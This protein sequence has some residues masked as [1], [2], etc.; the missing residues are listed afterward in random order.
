MINELLDPPRPRPCPPVFDDPH[1]RRRRIVTAFGTL[2]GALCLCVL[3]VAAGVLYTDA[4]APV[5]DPAGAVHTT[6]RR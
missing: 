1:G 2:V 5:P 4:E 6:G 3:A